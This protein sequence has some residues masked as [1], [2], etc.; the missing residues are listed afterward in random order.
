ML[1]KLGLP[2]LLL[3]AAAASQLGDKFACRPCFYPVGAVHEVLVKHVGKLPRKLVGGVIA[4]VQIGREG[5]ARGG[6]IGR[7]GEL[8]GLEQREQPPAHHFG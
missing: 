3:C 2:D 4:V 8:I 7:L 6:E 5:L 1:P